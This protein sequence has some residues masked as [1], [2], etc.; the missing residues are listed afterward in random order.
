MPLWNVLAIL[1]DHGP[2]VDISNKILALEVEDAAPISA[3]I[4]LTAARGQFLTTG[5]IIAKWD[6]IFLR[7]TDQNNNVAFESVVH[8]KKKKR[9]RVPG[10]GLG[11]ELTCP[12]QSSNI[13]TRT[14]SKPN[15]RQSGFEALNDAIA[16]ANTN[17][18][19][20]DPTIVVTTPFNITT[21]RGN[22]LSQ[23]TSNNYVFEAIKF[24]QAVK[25][26]LERE[27][28]PAEGGGNREFY[29][30]RF[31][32]RYDHG[33]GTMLDEVDIQCFQQGFIENPASTFSNTPTITLKKAILDDELAGTEYSNVNELDSDEETEQGTNLLLICDKNSGSK[34]KDF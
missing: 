7:I 31:V 11:V 30:F 22:N 24:E 23:E 29:F 1:K 3:K 8:V 34:P 27:G 9:K 25:E 33:A 16:Q 20:S 2:D 17:K 32:S 14:I 28:L 12:H 21:K 10:R 6:R 19:A 13:F 5:T 15:I 18:G 4:T 26:I